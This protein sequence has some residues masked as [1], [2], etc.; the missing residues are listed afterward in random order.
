MTLDFK[1]HVFGTGH[2][3]EAVIKLYNHHNLSIVD[4]ETLVS[5]FNNNN[6]DAKPPKVG[7]TVKVPIFCE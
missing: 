2:T 3:I 7:Q 4:I 1:E 6:P 5:I